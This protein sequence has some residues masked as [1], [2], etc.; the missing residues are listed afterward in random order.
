MFMR[1]GNER[2]STSF[3]EIPCQPITAGCRDVLMMSVRGAGGGVNS[4]RCHL[5]LK[6]KVSV[7]N[8]TS[9]H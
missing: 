7:A 8:E 6:D 3:Q 9:M 5:A 1:W 2:F 4:Q